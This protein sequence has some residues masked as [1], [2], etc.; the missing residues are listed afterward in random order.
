MPQMQ[1][2]DY[3][4]F[5]GSSRQD[6]CVGATITANGSSSYH[7]GGVVARFRSYQQYLAGYVWGNQPGAFNK[8]YIHE[9]GVVLAQMDGLSLGSEVKARLVYSGPNVTF[10]VD[11]DLDGTWDHILQATAIV[12]TGLNGVTSMNITSTPPYF[13]DWCHGNVPTP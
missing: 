3:L 2:G 1:Y 8:L 9:N 13:D 10:M 12:A 6:G 11:S 4:T 5:D 7:I